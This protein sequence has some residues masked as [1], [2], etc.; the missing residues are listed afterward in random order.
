MYARVNTFQGSPDRLDE[1]R[2]DALDHV[3]P[4]AR[5]VDGFLGLLS[6]VDRSSGREI[7]ITLW[8]DA[9]AMRASEGWADQVRSE[10]AELHGETIVSVER[11][12][13]A[14]AELPAFRT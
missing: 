12:E 4:L 9:D 6:L 14:I 3:L 1:S 5:R 11:Y 13:V 8:R 7:A 2:Q 10:G